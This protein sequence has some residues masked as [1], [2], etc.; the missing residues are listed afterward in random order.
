MEDRY[1]SDEELAR[2]TVEAEMSHK[3]KSQETDG[4]RPHVGRATINEEEKGRPQPPTLP[5]LPPLSLLPRP[6]SG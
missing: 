2:V 6:S 1:T 3:L 4:I 5:P